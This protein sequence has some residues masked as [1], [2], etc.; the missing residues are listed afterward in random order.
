MKKTKKLVMASLFCALCCIGTMIHLPA[1]PTIGYVHLGDA[2]VLL[3]GILL[4][5]L[6]GGL[7]SGVGSALADLINGYAIWIPGT[8]VTKALC[9]MICGFLF[10]IIRKKEHSFS[11]RKLYVT[12]LFGGILSELVMIIGYFFYEVLLITLSSGSTAT[13]VNA[14]SAALVSVPFN[15]IQSVVAIILILVIVP[16]LLRIEDVRNIILS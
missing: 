13:F 7:A 5:P 3:S 2:F 11:I 8:F 6:V 15:I 12:L 14:S 9:S 10:Y 4:G 16:I 1:G